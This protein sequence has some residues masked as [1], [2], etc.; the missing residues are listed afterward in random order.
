[1]KYKGTALPVCRSRWEYRFC[2][3]LDFNENVIEWIS[4]EPK[5]PYLNPNT[6]TM[7]NYHPDFVIR[8]KTLSGPPRTQMVE[9][10]PKKQ[11]VPPIV[12]KG[13]HQR[14]ILYEAC[15][16]R[17][18]CAKWEAAR[19]YCASRGWEFKILTEDNLFGC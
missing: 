9:I 5:I 6:N 17:Q 14:T 16:W 13:K 15:T 12:T 1:M 4:E 7:W 2:R 18:N 3:F 11:T 10:K 19:A 8:V